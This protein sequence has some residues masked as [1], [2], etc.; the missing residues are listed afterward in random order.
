MSYNGGV[1]EKT[2]GGEVKAMK[3]IYSMSYSEL[4]AMRLRLLAMR[5]IS[6]VEQMHLD[7]AD[8]VINDF[9]ARQRARVKLLSA[10]KG[11]AKYGKCS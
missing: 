11:V 4:S 6:G 2:S 5:D 8:S 9:E 3:S 10:L 7:Y 1:K